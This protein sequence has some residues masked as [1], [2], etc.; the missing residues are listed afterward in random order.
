MTLIVREVPRTIAVRIRVRIPGLC[1]TD[2]PGRCAGRTGFDALARIR[3]SG[4][5]RFATPT[6]S[7]VFSRRA[8]RCSVPDQLTTDAEPIWGVPVWNWS[9]GRHSI[10]FRSSTKH[11]RA[12]RGR[13]RLSGVASA[14]VTNRTDIDDCWWRDTYGGHCANRPRCHDFLWDWTLQHCGEFDAGNQW[15]RR[16]GG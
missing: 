5:L 14:P 12:A 9:P 16:R 1:R 8:G 13:I 15:W 4:C 11:P 7:P 2:K 10:W 6:E 3:W